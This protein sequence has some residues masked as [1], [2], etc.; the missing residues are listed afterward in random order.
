MIRINIIGS[1]G[2]DSTKIVDAACQQALGGF[3]VEI[4]RYLKT[5]GGRKN[6]SG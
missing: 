1:N 5:N 4:G 3:G 6:G 2:G